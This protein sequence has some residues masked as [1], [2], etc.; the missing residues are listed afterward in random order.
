MKTM[1]VVNRFHQTVYTLDNPD[2]VELPSSIDNFYLGELVKVATSD[3]S[4]DFFCENFDGT[5]ISH[6]RELARDYGLSFVQKK[7]IDYDPRLQV[8]IFNANNSGSRGV[9][10]FLCVMNIDDARKFCSDKQTKGTQS[11]FVFVE[12]DPSTLKAKSFMKDDGRFDGLIR[13]LGIRSVKHW[14]ELD[15]QKDFVKYLGKSQ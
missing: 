14:D 1:N 3:T 11:M 10:K 6:L 12:V 4:D 2:N 13:D 15:I 7:N 5:T 8:G 9:G